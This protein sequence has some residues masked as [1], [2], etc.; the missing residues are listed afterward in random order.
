MK[1]CTKT[2]M[3]AAGRARGRARHMAVLRARCARGSCP[4]Q[5]GRARQALARPVRCGSDRYSP[6]LPAARTTRFEEKGMFECSGDLLAARGRKSRSDMI[7]RRPA[8]RR[9]RSELVG[10][11]SSFMR[12]PSAGV[13]RG[14][15]SSS[16]WCRRV[17]PSAPVGTRS[18]M[19]AST[20]STATRAHRVLE[21]ARTGVAD[22][23]R[24]GGSAL[25]LAMRQRCAEV[26]ASAPI[27]I[28]EPKALN[29]NRRSFRRVRVRERRRG[30]KQMRCV[31]RERYIYI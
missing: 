27:A 5:G 4:E 29:K 17:R 20:P 1:F 6:E 10:P 11:T 28:N 24:R 31:Y 2:R 21:R 12:Q 22:A 9:G 8:P 15:L 13:G 30:C 3:G 14:G 25:R 23:P 18:M 26:G 7:D 19:R 16:T